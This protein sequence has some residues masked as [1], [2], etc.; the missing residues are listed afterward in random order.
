MT[1]LN[2]LHASGLSPSEHKPGHSGGL[3]SIP[4]RILKT[5]YRWQDAGK[6]VKGGNT[7]FRDQGPTR[8]DG[9]TDYALPVWKR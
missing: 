5:L 2:P 8:G 1:T 9:K 4:A 3:L 6:S 7:S